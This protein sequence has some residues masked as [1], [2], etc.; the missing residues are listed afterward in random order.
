MCL[1]CNSIY[2]RRYMKYISKGKRDRDETVYIAC[3]TAYYFAKSLEKR[4]FYMYGITYVNY[5]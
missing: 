3:W 5:S 1:T 2:G 4:K